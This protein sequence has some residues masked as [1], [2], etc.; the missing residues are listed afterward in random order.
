MY[1]RF[2]KAI[3]TL[4]D[5]KNHHKFNMSYTQTHTHI[6]TYNNDNLRVEFIGHLKE[7]N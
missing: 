4:P 1:Q 3:F 2:S 5:R 6:H 7:R